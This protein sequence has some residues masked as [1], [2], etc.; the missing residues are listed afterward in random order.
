MVTAHNLLVPEAV[1]MKETEKEVQ[2][3]LTPPSFMCSKCH[4]MTNLSGRWSI[5]HGRLMFRADEDP[6]PRRGPDLVSCCEGYECGDF[7][8]IVTEYGSEKQEFSRQELDEL[9]RTAA[10]ACE[11][12][13]K[14]YY[15]RESCQHT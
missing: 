9:R 4:F 10:N 15:E 7:T 5:E 14:R 13:M 3:L 8:K 6:Q 12:A 1:S 11:G 2:L